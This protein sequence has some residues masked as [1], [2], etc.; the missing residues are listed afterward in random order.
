[1]DDPVN[2]WCGPDDL[3]RRFGRRHTICLNSVPTSTT[4]T[5]RS[6]TLPPD[7]LRTF[8]LVVLDLIEIASYVYAGDQSV[9]RG[10]KTL[11]KDGQDWRR[12]FHYHIPVRCPDTWQNDE[13]KAALVKTLRFLSDDYFE[14]RL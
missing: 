11:P 1:M 12:E 10:G 9:S 3:P 8:R 14:F 7:W 2:I 6:R 13:I 4:S 5:S